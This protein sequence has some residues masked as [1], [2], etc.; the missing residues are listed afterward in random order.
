[1]NVLYLSYTGLAEP[2][3]QSQI[4]AYLR[5]LSGR[6]RITLVTFEKPADLADI[7]A[8]NALRAACAEYGIRWVARR[9]HHRPRLSATAFDLAVLGWTALRQARAG[10]AEL[11]H[12]R[13]YIPAFVALLVKRRLDLPFIFDMRAFWLEEMVTAGRLRRNSL[14]FRLLG[15]GERSCVRE[16]GAVVSLTEAAAGHLRR[17]HGGN[18]AHTRISVIPTCVD[19]DRFGCVPARTAKG[20]PAI[21][22][23]GSVLSGWFRLD[24]LMAFFGACAG[25][26]P[27][28]RFTVLTRDAPA[29]VAA[30]AA[31]A[32]IGPGRLTVEARTPSEMP[33]ALARLDAVA[34][35]FA[36]AI[37]E[38]ARC[39][40][41]M[42][43]A[44]AAGLPVIAND[45]V[46][47]VA[48][49]IRRHDV[50]VVVADASEPSMRRAAHDLS[51]LL[52]D[53]LLPGRCREAARASF[54]LEAGVEAYHALYSEIAAPGAAGSG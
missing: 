6:H 3:G 43:E 41:R 47:D 36:P 17:E 4:L 53:P 48:G 23:I 15:W 13:G 7:A 8:I 32:G 45:G 2:L 31:R 24:W 35:F 21:G 39:P 16:A 38:I 26:W 20:P 50:G 40:T 5:G 29:K 30:A 42:G 12:A 46:G 9:Y 33:Q 10:E 44:L 49:I 22:S 34:M 28:A 11:I 54:S 25:I 1:M 18:L 14:L 19:L 37:S 52:D 27:D 51:R